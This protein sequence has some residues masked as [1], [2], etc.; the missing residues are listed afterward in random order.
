[1]YKIV[2][3]RRGACVTAV[4]PFVRIRLKISADLIMTFGC[5]VIE[6]LLLLLLLVLP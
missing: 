6:A 2:G 5:I 1:M 3:R 4:P